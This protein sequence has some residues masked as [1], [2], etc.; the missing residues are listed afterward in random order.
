[1]NWWRILFLELRI[2]QV[3]KKFCWK[4]RVLPVWMPIRDKL[5]LNSRYHSSIDV[6]ERMIHFSLKPAVTITKQLCPSKR[7]HH[8]TSKEINAIRLIQLITVG[9]N[10][11]FYFWNLRYLLDFIQI[12]SSVLC[13]RL[14]LTITCR[15]GESCLRKTIRIKFSPVLT[16]MIFPRSF[17][18]REN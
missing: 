4:I 7:W 17:Y 13:F 9:N 15:R 11:Y 2:M 6:T 1:M 3:D 18:H 10:T 14:Y 8:R 5:C 16:S 12:S